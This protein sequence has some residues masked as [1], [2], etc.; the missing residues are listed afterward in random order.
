VGDSEDCMKT[1]QHMARS[2]LCVGVDVVMMTKND[3]ARGQEEIG[4]CSGQGRIGTFSFPILL[5]TVHLP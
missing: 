5:T 4:V 3:D 2:V 1:T